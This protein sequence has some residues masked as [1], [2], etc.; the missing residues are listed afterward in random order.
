ISS[1]LMRGGIDQIAIDGEEG[2]CIMSNCG[3]EA[4][5]LVLAARTV[6]KGILNLEV[7]RAV[8]EIQPLL[9]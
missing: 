8:G 9:A 7:K 4:V 2:Y 6:K 3:E 5:F 1:E